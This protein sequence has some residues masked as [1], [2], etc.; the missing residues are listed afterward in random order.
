VDYSVCDILTDRAKENM[1][2][3]HM[4]SLMTLKEVGFMLCKH[5]NRIDSGYWFSGD[6]WSIPT[7]KMNGCPE[8]EPV[9]FYHSHHSMLPEP[10]LSDLLVAY[11]RGY[12]YLCIS[13]GSKHG[14]SHVVVC[15]DI[16]PV[17]DEIGRL[18]E[19]VS[20]LGEASESGE[21]ASDIL[22]EIERV[23]REVNDVIER[24]SCSF[25]VEE[26]RRIVERVRGRRRD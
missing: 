11:D 9:G 16:S 17:W 24:N 1:K 14:D 25:E 7:E 10:S 15:Y 4:K 21:D 26:Y 6:E 2:E 3:A 22:A 12:P 5:D 18:S 8:G 19:L 20:E 13:G 23:E